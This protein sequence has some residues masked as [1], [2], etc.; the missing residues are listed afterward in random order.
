M[1]KFLFVANWKC[2]PTTL[3]EARNLFLGIVKKIKK[4]RQKEIVICPPF[5]YLWPL[6]K[7]N[8]S[9]KVV[10][11][12]QN[13]FFEEKGPFTGEISPKMLKD[14]GCRY[15]IVGH[16]ERRMLG[17]SDEIINK[18]IKIALKFKLT[19][20]L[21]IGENLKEKE[22]NESFL[23]IESQ[24]K[25]SL[26]KIPKKKL[27]EIVLAYEP[28][29]AIG[30]GKPSL[31]DEVL[32]VVIF[33]KKLFKNFFGFKKTEKISILYGGSVDFQNAKNYLEE[34]GVNGL[35]IGGSSLESQ[36]FLQIIS[37]C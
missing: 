13:L 2:N 8:K 16:S 9:K 18:K 30:T 26:H 23:R 5:V 32:S 17:E 25:K 24:I 21:C 12:A 19:P 22:N 31:V 3:R 37:S 33:I 29:W 35:L 14:L 6:L 7:L 28:I 27:A 1:K 4:T 15:V 36:K 34:A 20:I 11:G 10:L